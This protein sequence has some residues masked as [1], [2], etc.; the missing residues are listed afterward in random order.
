M[1]RPEITVADHTIHD[2]DLAAARLARAKAADRRLRELFAA[3]PAAGSDAFAVVG[4]GGYGRA[5]LS[6]HSDLDV[7][8]VHLPGTPAALVHEVA[9]ALWYPL[10]DDGVLL[11]HAVRDTDQ[12]RATAAVDLRAAVSMLDL[13]HVAGDGTLTRTLRSATLSDWRADAPRRLPELRVAGALRAAGAGEL[14][15]A[16]VPDLKESTGGLR[17]GVV[18]RSLVATWLVDVPHVEAE[19]CRSGLLDV[20][21]VLHEVSGRATDRLA[22]ELLPDMADLLGTT[23]DAL[24]R[25]V[26]LLGR[27]IAH[28]CQL[29]WR[30]LDQRQQPAARRGARRPGLVPLG[31]GV[32]RV[33]DEVVLA[34]DAQPGTDPV[35]A[36][37]VAALAAQHGLLIAPSTATRLSQVGAAMPSPWPEEARHL[38]TALLSTG[39]VLVPI[40]EELEH[41]GV[42]AGWLPEWS[43][44]VCRPAEAGIHRFTVDRHSLETCVEVSRRARDVDRPDLLVTAALLHDLGK[45]A[46]GRSRDHS[47]SGAELARSIMSRMGFGEADVHTVFELVALHLCLP[48]T[49][50]QRDLDDPATA[51]SVADRIGDRRL[52]NLLAVLAECDARAAS[53]RAWSSWRA[54]LVNRLVVQVR[55][56]LGAGPL[57][58]APAPTVPER[59]VPVPGH[60]VRVGVTS[61]AD[62][63]VVWVG[64]ADRVG[65]LA[66]VAGTLA[67]AGLDIRGCRGRIEADRLT[68][69]WDLST[70]RI[71]LA[72]LSHRLRRVLDHSV[73]L[74][75]RIEVDRGAVGPPPRVTAL[76]TASDTATV[77]EVRAGDRTGLLWRIF[78]S[79]ATTGIDVRSAHADTL[80]MHAVD[81][82]Y[83]LGADGKPLRDDRVAELVDMLVLMLSARQPVISPQRSG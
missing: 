23:P 29:T 53:P 65:L 55:T 52:L 79:L 20:R 12:M 47:E 69:Q 58:E 40:W 50:T 60:D 31:P 76:D 34:T 72:A 74:D 28:L 21:D 33:G 61:R 75:E 13:R 46:M 4:V 64:G 26:R 45:A 27:R 81:V 73:D 78:S 32:A 2:G 7:V 41:A 38:F 67:W 70:P 36:L 25:H 3:T 54:A 83:V 62:G 8:L 15:H 22:P 68:S 82:L 18:L 44:V 42:V 30:R 66:D 9:E 80:G 1:S 11:D 48:V 6:P 35:L 71:D 43:A 51:A 19:A 10:W 57:V 49:A 63:A 59:S 39:P 14:A 24:G 77:L 37:R 17:D 16:G 56:H 5:D